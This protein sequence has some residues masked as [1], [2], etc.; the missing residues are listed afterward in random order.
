MP[1]IIL[2]LAKAVAALAVKQVRFMVSL[3]RRD[4]VSYCLTFL[5]IIQLV[6]LDHNLIN[7]SLFD[8][9][10]DYVTSQ[11]FNLINGYQTKCFTAQYPLPC[12]L[13]SAVLLVNSALIYSLT[14]GGFIH[15]VEGM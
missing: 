6:E 11:V 2:N 4:Y 13:V 12:T 14:R 15:H 7:S 5:K 8:L 10:M 9:S 1:V 3:H